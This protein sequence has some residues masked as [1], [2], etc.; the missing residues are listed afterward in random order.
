VALVGPFVAAVTPEYFHILRMAQV[1]GRLFTEFD[2]ETAP[3][4]AVINEAMARI[5]RR[6]KLPRAQ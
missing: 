1:R 3:G 5:T 4:V 2:N 6:G